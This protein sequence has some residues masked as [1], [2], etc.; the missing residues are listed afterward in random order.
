MTNEDSTPSEA[1]DPGD[2]LGLADEVVG[3]ATGGKSPRIE[4]LEILQETPRRAQVRRFAATMRSIIDDLVSTTATAEEL[5]EASDRLEEIARLIAALPSGQEYQGFAEAANAG[6]AMASGMGDT[7]SGYAGRSLLAED[8]PERFAVFDHSPFIGLA[9]PLSP[10]MRLRSESD[11]VIAEV[12]FGVAYEG[13]PGCV[14]GGYVA[15]AFDECLG[16]TQ[17]LSGMAGMTAHLGIDYRSPTPLRVPLVMEGRLDRRDG[18]KIW[19]RATLHAGDRLC[20]EAEGL[21]IAFDAEKFQE[22]LEARQVQF[23]TPT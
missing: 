1:G 13:P 12:T 10:P 20:A 14:H 15:A 3:I 22:L 2:L 4:G 8:D 18:R 19:A 11:R 17:S 23:G 7:I 5:D 6:A 21:F 16:A 9:N